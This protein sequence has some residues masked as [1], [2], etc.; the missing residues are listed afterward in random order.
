MLKNMNLR[1]K[2]L[3]VL[4]LISVIPVLIVSVILYGQAKEGMDDT[5]E[6]NMDQAIKTVDYYFKDK[7][8]RALS[9]AKKY[10]KDDMLV[11]EFKNKNRDVLNARIK[12]IFK[13]LKEEGITV[14]E[15]E[16]Q[17]GIVFT[18]GHNVD[19]YGDDK[20]DNQAIKT[21]LQGKA[22]SG[23]ALGK[24]GLA[25]RGFAPIKNREDQV[26]GA[27]QIGFNLNDDM[28]KDISDLISGNIAFYKKDKLIQTSREE[29]QDKVGTNLE[30][31]SIFK[32]IKNGNERVQ[33]ANQNGALETFHPLY[34]PSGNEIQGMI[35]ISQS[36]KFMNQFQQQVL[37][38]AIISIVVILIL[39]FLF[40]SFFSK[41]ITA[42][43]ISAMEFITEIANGNLNV[44][45]LQVKTNDEVGNLI[46]SLNKMHQKLKEMIGSLVDTTENLSA[47]SEELSASAQ[48][49]NAVIGTS[50]QNI[51]EMTASIQQISASSQ[52][53]TGI[54]QEAN[55]K[56][57]VGNEKVAKAEM[58]MKQI[59]QKIKTTVSTISSLDDKSQEIGQIVEL[60]N[61]I[62]D[63]TNLL[64]LN[65][66]IEAARAGEHGQ[67]FAV[68][69]EEIREL[70]EETAKA[71]NEIANLVKETQEKSSSGL[72]AIKQ[73]E[74]ES[75]KGEEIAIET[76]QIFTKIKS[77][78]E[79]TSA[80][81]QQTAAS[82]QDLAKNSDEVM[83]AS[84]D[85]ENV[86]QEVANASQELSGMAQELQNLVE[87]FKL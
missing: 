63:Q 38:V 31:S 57:Q 37:K 60:I 28:L 30:D 33:V 26:I 66:A 23:F 45:K 58:G 32:Q 18:R 80:H 21:A 52:Q 73:V 59:N 8:E 79:D 1:K 86:A 77:S 87:E 53:V 69:A 40:S 41:K 7:K 27:F 50:M 24:S 78:I 82:T 42:P 75:K 68:V 12:P 29:E 67:G 11:F 39:V 48:E 81:I 49:G 62:A 22:V 15:F 5:V 43:I 10:A 84:E 14:F 47:H 20:S 44:E 76:G 61:D 2:L 74:N 51:E 70:A 72:K 71:T 17:D 65:A 55:S 36:L 6:M 16:D 85:I 13:S 9:L 83:E 64:A 35:R 3:S 4:I 46:D 34:D 56:T 54:A 19:K 25:V